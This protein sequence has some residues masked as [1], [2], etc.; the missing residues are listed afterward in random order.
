MNESSIIEWYVKNIPKVHLYYT[1]LLSPFILCADMVKVTFKIQW[2][3]EKTLGW[4]I[5]ATLFSH[6]GKGL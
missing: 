6:N 5:N 4:K 2:L 1:V 3:V